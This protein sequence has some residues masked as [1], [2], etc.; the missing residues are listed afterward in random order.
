MFWVSKV[1]RGLSFKEFK[2]LWPEIDHTYQP[3]FPPDIISQEKAAEIIQFCRDQLQ[4]FE[5]RDDYREVLEVTILAL[6]GEVGNI[7]IKEPGP[8]HHARWMSKFIY[9]FKVYL[10][11]AFMI[12][13]DA[14]MTGTVLCCVIYVKYWFL[15]PLTTADSAP[16][17]DLQLIKDLYAYKPPL[18]LK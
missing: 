4:Q 9:A 8:M 14:E 6:G 1:T 16:A 2:D 10:F 18:V 5:P 17:N 13:T 3:G 12:L 7:T 11:R 15:S